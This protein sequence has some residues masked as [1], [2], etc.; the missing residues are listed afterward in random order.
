[1]SALQATMRCLIS[2]I[3]EVGGDH[4]LVDRAT[5]N[6]AWLA[7]YIAAADMTALLSIVAEVSFVVGH[8]Y[9]ISSFRKMFERDPG[10][11]RSSYM[12]NVRHTAIRQRL[13]ITRLLATIAA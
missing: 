7:R 6:H 5:L 3:V 11:R 9:G 2:L 4:D 13:I 12:N 8:G 10:S 1:M